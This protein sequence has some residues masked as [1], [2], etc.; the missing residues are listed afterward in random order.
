M[1]LPIFIIPEAL[2]A[3]TS[4]SFHLVPTTDFLRTLNRADYYKVM[5]YCRTVRRTMMK[6]AHDHRN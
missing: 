2:G 4:G 6:A 5:R 3:V 1:N